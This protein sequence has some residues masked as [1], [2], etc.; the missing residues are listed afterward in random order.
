MGNATPKTSLPAD[1]NQLKKEGLVSLAKELDAQLNQPAA[2]ATPEERSKAGANNMSVGL[3]TK[4]FSIK[5]KDGTII[6]GGFTFKVT[7]SVDVYAGGTKEEP[8]YEKNI[9]VQETWFKAWDNGTPV[10]TQL[11]ELLS[12]NDWALVRLF[13]N[14][15]GGKSSG[16]IDKPIQRTNQDGIV[17]DVLDAD[18][19]PKTRRGLQ[20]A[21]DKRVVGFELLKAGKNAPT[22]VAI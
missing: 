12:T 16:I 14:F 1:F 6:P 7:Q 3:I 19:K 4:V 13:W 9:F 17:E 11:N 22:N 20:Y 21:P 18:G 2:E 5:K 15:D 8:K 10:G